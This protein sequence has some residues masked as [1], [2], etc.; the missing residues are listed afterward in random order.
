MRLPDLD[1]VVRHGLCAGCG[2][3][4][5][6]LGRDNVE[7][8]LTSFGQIRPRVKHPLDRA[9][10]DE[11]LSVCPGATVT[12]P[13]PFAPGEDGLM[14]P[15]WGPIASLHRIWAADE[16][17]RFRAA[18]GGSLTALGCY[19]L[20]SGEVDAILHVA[21]S[22]SQ[23]V[24]TDARISYTPEEVIEGAQSHYGPAAPLIHVNALLDRGLRFA[25]IAKPCD[26]AAIRNLGRI[27]PRV[28]A[29]IPFCLT[30]FCGGV[31]TV[32]TANK[33]AAYV[34]VRPNDLGVFRWRGNGWPGPTHLETRDGRAF[35]LSYDNVWYD[36]SVPWTCDIQFRCKICPDAIGE[37][38]DVACPDGWVMEDGKPIH[39]EAPGVNIAVA[40]TAAGRALVQRAAAAGAVCL[41]PFD[42]P[43]LHAMHGDHLERKLGFPARNLGLRLSG[44]P[45]LR[46]R[47]VRAWA[48]FLRAGLG[49]NWRAFRGALRRGRAGANREPLL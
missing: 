26:I 11:V 30:I 15:V 38:A 49:G 45:R 1:S 13:S 18:A 42:R 16:A 19:L 12:G 7:M 20:R 40:R 27:D 47:R 31:P 5:S 3:C 48:A 37:L 39:R 41:A 9:R 28:E 24:L 35:D 8:R 2:I 21:A 25:V 29:Q 36:A 22:K 17:I 46:V 14:D 4:Q 44:Q 23:P 34:G 32:H 10:L 33:I 43:A 6:M